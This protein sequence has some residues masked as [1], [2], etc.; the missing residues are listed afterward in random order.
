MTGAMDW[1]ETFNTNANFYGAPDFPDVHNEWARREWVSGAQGIINAGNLRMGI[2]KV[3]MHLLP[4]VPHAI[5]EEIPLKY[6]A[7][8]VG[9]YLMSGFVVAALI[10]VVYMVLSE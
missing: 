1:D 9:S 4:D 10:G 2:Q 7:P 6:G 3:P 5:S 8:D